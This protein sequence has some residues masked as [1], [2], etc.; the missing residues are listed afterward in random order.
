MR[1]NHPEDIKQWFVFDWRT[2]SIRSAAQ[3]NMAISVQDSNNW[4]YFNYAAVVKPFRNHAT[5]KIRWFNGDSRNI[6]DLGLR[7]INV[8]GGRN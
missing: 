1:N 3:R 2:R 5:S 8:Y 4:Y 7:C 6:R